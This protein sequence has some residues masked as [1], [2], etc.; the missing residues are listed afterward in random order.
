MERVNNPGSFFTANTMTSYADHL[1]KDIKNNVNTFSNPQSFT[2]TLFLLPYSVVEDSVNRGALGLVRMISRMGL[3]YLSFN[4]LDSL[5][6][7]ILNTSLAEICAAGNIYLGGDLCLDFV[8]EYLLQ[9]EISQVE[10][11]NQSNRKHSPEDDKAY[12]YAIDALKGLRQQNR[13]SASAKALCILGLLSPNV[14]SDDSV[15]KYVFPSALAIATLAVCLFTYR[16]R[17]HVS[18][19]KSYLDSK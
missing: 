14:L 7:R 12:T 18:E 8:H 15:F 1:A 17:K 2:H 4:Y 9:Q 11:F 10:A 19:A 3:G 13:E 6:K 5:Q 16:D